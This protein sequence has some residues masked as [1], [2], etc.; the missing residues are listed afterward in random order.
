MVCSLGQEGFLSRGKTYGEREK[1]GGALGG[2]CRS[3]VLPGI[4]ICA[5]KDNKPSE[6]QGAQSLPD[7]GI[8]D[9]MRCPEGK[10]HSN[11]PLGD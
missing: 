6:V 8:T 10:I 2:P 1:R 4:Y 7:A 9:T 3:Q 11:S 5:L